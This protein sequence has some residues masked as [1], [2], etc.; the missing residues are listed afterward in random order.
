MDK[1]PK[2]SELKEELKKVEFKDDAE[3]AADI[4]PK[5]NEYQ[6]KAKYKSSPEKEK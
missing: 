3:F 4:A 1:S 6:P 2:K 5:T